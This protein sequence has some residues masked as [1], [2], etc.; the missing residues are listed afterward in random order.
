MMKDV[1]VVIFGVGA[2]GAA[3]AR[4]CL[5]RGCQIV[6]AVDIAEDKVGHDLADV[7]GLDQELGVAI[8]PSISEAVDKGEADVTL[9]CS[10]S[11]IG[12][13]HPQLAE[14]AL[15]GSNVVS[16]CEE[17]AF[18]WRAHRDIAQEI[19][20]AA[21]REGVTILGTGVNP[22]FVMDA[23]AIALSSMCTEVRRV[24]VERIVDV[25]R[26]RLPLQKKVGAGLSVQEFTAKVK[27]AKLGHVGT[28]ESIDMLAAAFGWNLSEVAVEIRPAIAEGEV[29]SP[30]L[31]VSK[32]QSAGIIQT[33]TGL[34]GEEELIR[35]DL[36]MYM[37]ARDPRDALHLE[38]SP[39]VEVHIPGGVQGDEATVAAV[40]NAIPLVMEAEP[41]LRTMLDLPLPHYV[42]HRKG[43]TNRSRR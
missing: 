39:G 37:G 10:T 22:G 5:L 40:V 31:K 12:E 15:T 8:S 19:D 29:S 9:H 1:K 43:A 27:E 4:Q 41:G 6:G 38:G 30:E 21:R 24:H 20:Q 36:Q 42:G 26:R 3:L 32:G 28:Q 17:L 7:A 14:I 2:I 13:A 33:G 25:A 23:L 35:L 18:P 16:T 34:L 11:Y